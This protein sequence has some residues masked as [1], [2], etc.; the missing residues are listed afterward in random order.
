MPSPHFRPSQILEFMEHAKK[1]NPDDKYGTS[2]FR[3]VTEG[4]L[5]RHNADKSVTYYPF[6]V[7]ALVGKNDDGTEEWD[8]RP[9]SISCRKANTTKG[10]PAPDNRGKIVDITTNFNVSSKST[11]IINGKEI[12][13]SENECLG[14]VLSV[15]IKSYRSIMKKLFASRDFEEEKIFDPLQERLKR[16][17]GQK[18]D[19]A[20]LEL[21]DHIIRI[22]IP[23]NAEKTDGQNRKISLT[24]TP[25][26]KIYDADKRNEENP[27]TPYMPATVLDKE[28]GEEVEINYGNIQEFVTYGSSVTG[29]IDMGQVSLSGFGFSLSTSW[30]FMIV[31]HSPPSAFDLVSAL[32][33]DQLFNLGDAEVKKEE[34]AK[35]EEKP[36]SEDDFSDEDMADFEV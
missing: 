10:I 30:R 33:E 6:Q 31:K 21:K 9:V 3:I 15:I 14:K 2:A 34:P 11:W 27:K 19:P 36:A 16:K 5:V 23:F 18:I 25:R 7:R 29:A 35:K 24:Q 17:P 32:G 13:E 1:V 8:W 26:T 12:E 4:D 28:T 20:K 22:K